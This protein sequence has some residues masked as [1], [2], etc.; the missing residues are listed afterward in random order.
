MKPLYPLRTKIWSIIILP[1]VLLIMLGEQILAGLEEM[2]EGIVRESKSI[3]R[4]YQAVWTET[5]HEHEPDEHAQC[6]Q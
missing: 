5:V 2:V 6:D 1:L 4:I 3:A